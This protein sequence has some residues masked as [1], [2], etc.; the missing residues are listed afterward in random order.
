M[1][2]RGFTC[3]QSGVVQASAL[4]AVVQPGPEGLAVKNRGAELAVRRFG[5]DRR[6]GS[7]GGSTPVR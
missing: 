5:H 7:E 1:G 3:H 4:L 6:T 2:L